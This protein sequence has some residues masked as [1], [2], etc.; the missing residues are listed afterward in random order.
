MIRKAIKSQSR[1]IA[2]DIEYQ[3]KINVLITIVNCVDKFLHRKFNIMINSFDYLIV[4]CGYAGSVLAERIANVLD[5]KVLIV[6]KRGHIAGNAYDY[7]NEGGILVHKYGPHIFHTNSKQV[8]DYL[9]QFTSWRLYQHRVLAVIEGKKIPIPFNLNSVYQCFSPHLAE[10][11]EKKLIQN[12]GFNKKVPILDLLKVEDPEV[13]FLADYIYNNI[14]LNYNI[15]QWGLKP[16]ELDKSVSS[17]VPIF[18][19]RDDRYFHDIY[20]GIPLHGYTVMFQNILNHKNIHL[21]LN[22]DYKDVVD[23]IKFNHLIFTGPLD[24]FFDYQFGQLPY[25]SLEFNFVTEDREYYQELAQVNYPN[26]YDYT[27]ITEFKYLS[28]QILNKTTIAFE[29]PDEYINGKNEPYYPI[30]RDE[31][32]ELFKK[33]I[34]EAKKIKNV[35]FLGRLA[36]YKYYNM[37]QIVAR[38]LMIFQKE[39]GI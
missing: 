9:S 5:K 8:W 3:R 18:I 10:K 39:I 34:D 20:Q 24:Y 37:D 38:A 2:R 17:R 26:N 35:S 6:E 33:Y 15:K 22:T 30:P 14:F 1:I 23:M 31:N 12:F 27:R 4:G 11:L 28:G 25:R 19:G 13:K 16:E 32:N 36:D 21:L 29:Y 7:Y